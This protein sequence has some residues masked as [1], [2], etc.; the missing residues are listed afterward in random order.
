MRSRHCRSTSAGSTSTLTLPVVL[1]RKPSR[2]S[3]VVVLPAPLGPQEREHLAA[4]TVKSM[5]RTAERSVSFY[6]P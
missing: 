5:P 2:I 4:S 6:E 3:R 1:S